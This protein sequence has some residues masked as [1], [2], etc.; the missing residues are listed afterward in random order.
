MIQFSGS[1]AI[2]NTIELLKLGIHKLEKCRKVGTAILG[3]VLKL[4]T[5]CRHLL[6]G[7]KTTKC[8]VVNRV[9]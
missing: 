4:V 3:K 5:V 7:D 1:F 8:P 6:A 9:Q 2:R